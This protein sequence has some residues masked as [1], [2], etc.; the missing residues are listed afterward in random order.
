MVKIGPHTQYRDGAHL[1]PA[2]TGRENNS[3]LSIDFVLQDGASL[4]IPSRSKQKNAY[5]LLC[6]GMH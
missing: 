5:K 3:S 1:S 4:L 2:H 6:G